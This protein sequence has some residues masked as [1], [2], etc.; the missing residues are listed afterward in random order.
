MSDVQISDACRRNLCV[1]QKPTATNRIIS[2]EITTS[3]AA[4]ISFKRLFE[5]T[6]GI[7]LTVLRSPSACR[8][9]MVQHGGNS[10]IVGDA[11]RF[12]AVSV[13]IPGSGRAASAGVVLLVGAGPGTI[14]WANAAGARSHAA[15]AIKI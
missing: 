6:A 2:A 15:D 11:L 14:V 7:V 12:A 5:R 9:G 3:A 4:H 8:S 1:S 13:L 10:S